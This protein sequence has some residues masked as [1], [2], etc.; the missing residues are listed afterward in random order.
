MNRRSVKKL[1]GNCQ[2]ITERDLL[3]GLEELKLLRLELTHLLAD[4]SEC[5]QMVN[6][7][8]EARGEKELTFPHKFNVN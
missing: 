2:S 4:I 7:V 6:R 1:P 3:L 8:V 5:L